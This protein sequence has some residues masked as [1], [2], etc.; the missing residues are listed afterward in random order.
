MNF[1]NDTHELDDLTRMKSYETHIEALQ[2]REDKDRDELVRLGKKPV[3]KVR[4]YPQYS[5]L[6]P[7]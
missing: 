3:L 1:Q 4:P 2:R 6:P 7:V 5:L